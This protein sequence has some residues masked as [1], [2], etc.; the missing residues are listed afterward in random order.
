MTTQERLV[1][2]LAGLERI[3]AT[4]GR[5]LPHLKRELRDLIRQTRETPTVTLPAGLLCAA[6]V[7][8]NQ[9]EALTHDVADDGL[10][11]DPPSRPL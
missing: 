9:P 5:E 4:M 11:D 3:E 1:E 2:L 10:Y 8:W 7:E 6:E